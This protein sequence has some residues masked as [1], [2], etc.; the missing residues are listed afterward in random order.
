MELTEKE[1]KE[2][3]IKTASDNYYETEETEGKSYSELM[4]MLMDKF[5]SMEKYQNMK[6][7]LGHRKCLG[8]GF[9]VC[10]GGVRLVPC[11]CLKEKKKR[12]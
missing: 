12:G 10:A 8:R 9:L 2:R 5:Y 11:N 3:F 4:K 1:F 6:P 7:R